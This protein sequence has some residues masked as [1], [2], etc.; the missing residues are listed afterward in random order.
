MHRYFKYTSTK[1][2]RKISRIIQVSK[3]V[4]DAGIERASVYT[5]EAMSL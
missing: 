2:T 4:Q 1:I 3:T 5:E